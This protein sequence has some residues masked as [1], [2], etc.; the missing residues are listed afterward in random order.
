MKPYIEQMPTGGTPLLAGDRYR[1]AAPEAV[2]LKD[3]TIE[4]Q[5]T[6]SGRQQAVRGHGFSNSLDKLPQGK[7]FHCYGSMNASSFE[8]LISREQHFNSSRPVRI[9]KCD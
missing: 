5:P 8:T 7:G 4:H 6:Q 3:R 2:T 1:L 9:C